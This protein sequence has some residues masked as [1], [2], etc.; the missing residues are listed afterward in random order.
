MRRVLVT[1]GTRPEAIKMAPVVAALRARAAEL[2]VRSCVTA[3]HRHL[4]DQVNALFGIVPDIDLALMQPGQSLAALTA[5]VLEAMTAVLEAER[6]DVVLVHGDTTTAMATALAAFYR[7][8]PVGH[9]EAGLRSGRLD[10]PFPEE[11]NRVLIDRLAQHLWAPTAGAARNL[12][13]EGLEAGRIV[14]TGNTAVDALALART[15]LSGAPLAVPALLGGARRLALVTAH[16]RESFGAPLAEAFRG[17]AALA[18][19]HPEV[20]FAYPVHPNPQVEG[21][22]RASLDLPNVRL[23]PPV[24]YGDLVWLLE[25]AE[26]VLTDSGGIQEEAATLGKPLLV[27]REVTERPEIVEAGAGLLV[28]TDAQRIE[29]EGHRL[30]ADAAARAAFRPRD[31]FGDGHAAQRIAAALCDE[32]V[33]PWQPAA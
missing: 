11:L 26:L 12:S 3:Q 29:A 22:A 10:A 27:L 21:P 15:R 16:R 9:V 25:R 23:L 5:R 18:R 4:L 17:I 28:G 6:P 1:Y 30:L 14:V 20:T 13:R 31:L 8:V 7:G 33:E 19:R 2:V 32:P 24:E